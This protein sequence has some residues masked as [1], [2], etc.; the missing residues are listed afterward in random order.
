MCMCSVC[1]ELPLPL[2]TCFSFVFTNSCL[3]I[4]Y[5]SINEN[6]FISSFIH[7]II[8]ENHVFL[9]FSQRVVYI[10]S[11]YLNE[12]VYFFVYSYDN[13]NRRKS[14]CL[15]VLFSSF[16]FHSNDNIKKIIC[17]VYYDFI[18]NLKINNIFDCF[19]VGS[20]TMKF[21]L[22]NMIYYCFF[23]IVSFA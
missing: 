21:L 22:N 15:F 19:Y 1:T 17:F 5:I 10:S 18:V 7:M 20:M 3:S 23:V 12:N 8:E 2:E 14:L 6:V 13:D 9:L 11:L 4:S 16:F